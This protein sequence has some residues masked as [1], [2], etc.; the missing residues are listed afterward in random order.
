MH[1][2]AKERSF[3]AQLNEIAVTQLMT[4]ALR[5]QITRELRATKEVSG[6]LNRSPLFNLICSNISVGFSLLQFA[7]MLC[8]LNKPGSDDAR[9]AAE[10]VYAKS[11]VYS[12]ELS[13]R[14][15]TS[16]LFN[17]GRLRTALDEFRPGNEK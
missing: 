16:A 2:E 10:K 3:V 5:L 4:R 11:I 8:Q 17:L 14:E 7:E 6:N 13:T 9:N 15:R 1:N 12:K